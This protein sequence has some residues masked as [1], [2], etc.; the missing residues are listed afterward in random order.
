MRVAPQSTNNLFCR[1]PRFRGRTVVTRSAA[2]APARLRSVSIDLHGIFNSHKP[3]HPAKGWRLRV[4]VISKNR[5][6]KWSTGSWLETNRFLTIV[7]NM[8]ARSC[9]A[10]TAWVLTV[11]PGHTKGIH[12]LA[13]SDAGEAN[14]KLR[15]LGEDACCSPPASV[16]LCATERTL[17][18]TAHMA[19]PIR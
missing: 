4:R 6:D 12:L 18:L 2:V 7:R 1:F 15:Q 8:P 14:S 19:P 5:K 13:S 17:S 3:L 11:P 9:K 16:E 10:P